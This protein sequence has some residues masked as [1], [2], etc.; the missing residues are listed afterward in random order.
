MK[1][2]SDVTTVHP[3]VT[4]QKGDRLD[5][6]AKLVRREIG[7]EVDVALGHGPTG[8]KVIAK[9]DKGRITSDMT[10]IDAAKVYSQICS[11]CAFWDRAGWAATRKAW[12][13]PSNREGFVVLNKIRAE[14]LDRGAADVEALTNGRE[15]DD[16]EHALGDLAICRPLTDAC[17]EITLTH[18]VGCCPSALED[19]TPFED[20]FRPARGGAAARDVD[21]VYDSILRKAQGR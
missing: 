19:G 8:G 9:S 7:F 13:D 15:L 20:T 16:V 3:E 11:R 4:D 5:P 10:A 1:P 12:S 2:I 21:A 17:H 18:A 6:E 14:L